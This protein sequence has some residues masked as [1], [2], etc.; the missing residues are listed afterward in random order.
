MWY[1]DVENAKSYSPWKDAFFEFKKGR[2]FEGLFQFDEF[3]R[4]QVRCLKTFVEEYRDAVEMS[5]F[6]QA[7]QVS[8]NLSNEQYFAL[9]YFLKKAI[10]FHYLNGGV[11]DDSMK[12]IDSEL[13][14]IGRKWWPEL[15]SKYDW[16]EVYFDSKQYESTFEKIAFLR[17][18][19]RDYRNEGDNLLFV[20]DPDFYSKITEEISYLERLPDAKQI[21]PALDAIFSLGSNPKNSM[22]RETG[23]Y[24]K[25][26]LRL[27][28]RKG[29][30]TNLIRVIN[31]LYELRYFENDDGQ[32]PSKKDVFV[33]FGRFLNVDFSKYAGSLSQAYN[34]GTE[35]SNTAIFDEMRGKTIDLIEQATEKK[36]NRT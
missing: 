13:R 19:Y 28:S 17:D 32:I 18:R 25:S 29:T 1:H 20:P 6:L 22:P 26:K 34:T 33:A 35:S 11:P 10:R 4:L 7:L 9:L 2:Y 30:N 3:I 12:I 23:E 24:M 27:R 5:E 14:D 31:A 21:P 8:E 16:D 15:A 36:K